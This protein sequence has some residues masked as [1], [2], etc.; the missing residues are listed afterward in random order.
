[1]AIAKISLHCI[2]N[3][4]RTAFLTLVQYVEKKTLSFISCKTANIIACCVLWLIVF[5][6]FKKNGK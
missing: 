3:Q 6:F 4:N 5:S 1:M 2:H